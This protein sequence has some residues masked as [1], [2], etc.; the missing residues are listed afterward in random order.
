MDKMMKVVFGLIGLT[1]LGTFLGIR[2]TR[3]QVKVERER[4][5]RISNSQNRM[6][7]V[8]DQLGKNEEA[9]AK[10]LDEL[11]KKIDELNAKLNSRRTGGKA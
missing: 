3:K 1:G 4:I 5:D 6:Y 9:Y 2:K 7:D 10:E 8:M 11:Q